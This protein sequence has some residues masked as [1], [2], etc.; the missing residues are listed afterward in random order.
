M[1][2]RYSYAP[3]LPVPH[4]PHTGM[5]AKIPSSFL[6]RQYSHRQDGVK[7]PTPYKAVVKT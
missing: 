2:F 4:F 7:N 6:K 1:P 3:E 5:D